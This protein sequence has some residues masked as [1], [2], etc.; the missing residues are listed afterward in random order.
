MPSE[1]AY[2]YYPGCSQT[3]TSI[4][5]DMSTRASCKALGLQLVDLEDWSCCGSTPA[6]TVD[7]LLSAALAARNLRIVQEMGR[8]AVVTPCPSCL[9]ALRTANHRMRN[10]SFRAEVNDIIDKPYE[11][12]IE[13]KSVLQVI[14]EEVGPEKIRA[15]VTNPLKG[16]AAAPY[17]GCIMSRPPEVMAFDDP[18][19]PI[20]MDKILEALGAEVTPFPFKVEC[21]GAAHAV[22]KKDVVTFLSGRILS[23]AE[24]FG[25]NA[26]VV[27]CPLCHQNLDLRQDQINRSQ[28]TRFKLPILYFTQLIAL[29]MGVDEKELGLNKHHVSPQGLLKHIR[30][31]A[32][33][34]DETVTK[35]S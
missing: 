23:M 12:E 27:A 22:P 10:P 14:Y 28:K 16:L 19:N 8:D 15:A 20:A 17:Y 3:G 13:A 30:E 7:H 2:L 29:A 18:E 9:T 31:A 34:V 4:E 11:G 26:I 21:C 33:A 6:H 5:Y 24:E 32:A 1:Q 25:A 35:V